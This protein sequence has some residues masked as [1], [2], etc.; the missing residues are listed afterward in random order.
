MQEQKAWRLDLFSGPQKDER[1]VMPCHTLLLF[2][3]VGLEEY[4]REMELWNHSQC[5]HPLLKVGADSHQQNRPVRAGK[6]WQD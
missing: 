3:R 2:H 6:I 4:W 5:I 1:L